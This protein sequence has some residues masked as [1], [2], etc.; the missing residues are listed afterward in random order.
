MVKFYAGLLEQLKVYVKQIAWLDAPLKSKTTK[1][2]EP[3]E[4]M[5]R[6]KQFAANRMDADFPPLV[7]GEYLIGYLS[8]LGFVERTGFGDAQ[9]SCQEVRAWCDGTGVNLNAWE[10]RVIRELS[11]AFVCQSSVSEEPDCPAPYIDM[12]D[13][14][15]QQRLAQSIERV[16]EA[17]IA[18]K[19]KRKTL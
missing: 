12:P 1:A 8:E 7:A 18:R 15:K 13:E 16:F 5:T 19:S 3:A 10:F 11:L 17:R 9:L 2:K 4:R 14:E 6:R